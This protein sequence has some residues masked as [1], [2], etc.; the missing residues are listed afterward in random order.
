MALN[1]AKITL[2]TFHSR[3]TS[4]KPGFPYGSQKIRGVNLGGWLVLEPWI[5]PSI[6]DNTGD[7]RV[8]DEYTFGQY[9]NPSTAISVL[10]NHWNTWITE[11]DFARMA[12]AGLNHIRLPIGY[13]A[14]DVS[15]GEPYHQGQL[16]YLQKAVT[17]AGKYGL[18][19]IVD[20]H[21]AP[22]SQNGF[23][24]S[25]QRLSYPRWQSNPNNVARTLTIMSTLANMFKSQTNIVTAIAALNEPAGFD[26]DVLPVTRQYWH[27]SYERI[28]Y[29]SGDNQESNL[30][31][32]I[33]D[34]FQDLSQWNGFEAAPNFQG[35]VMDTHVYQMFS[36]NRVAQTR[37]QH[38]ASACSQRS[39]LASYTTLWTVVGEWTT[40]STDCAKYLNGRGSGSRYDGSYPGSKFIGSCVGLTG[41]AGSFSSTYKTFMRQYYEAQ[42]KNVRKLSIILG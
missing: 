39:R 34:A 17:W 30:I 23:D 33:H 8:V 10:Q 9:V 21:G 41:N 4:I 7:T 18:K 36:N 3:D 5:T 14:F 26:S 6:F 37:E 28:R 1:L 16:P 32:V 22:G 20:L 15:S 11:E 19:V 13:W 38:I 12:E 24:N 29:P 27:D 2:S 42:V 40:G 35:V 31:Q 25:G